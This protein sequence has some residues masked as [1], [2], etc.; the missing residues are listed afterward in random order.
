MLEAA[1][2]ARVKLPALETV[3]EVYEQA[4]GDKDQ[5]YAA[6]IKVLENLAGMKA[7]EGN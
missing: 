5:D 6:T 1:Q 3:A 4:Q 2:D 7:E